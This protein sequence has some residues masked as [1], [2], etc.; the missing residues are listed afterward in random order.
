M[1]AH[2]AWP[3]ILF[4]FGHRPSK[5]LWAL[6]IPGG[7][8]PATTWLCPGRRGSGWTLGGAGPQQREGRRA[9]KSLIRGRQ[10]PERGRE[11]ESEGG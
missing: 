6:L 4:N 3:C 10:L 7:T 5:E 1:W 8:M 2:G 11:G 9:I